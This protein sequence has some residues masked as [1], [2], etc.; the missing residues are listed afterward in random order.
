MLSGRGTNFFALHQ[1]IQ[2][3]NLHARIIG[4]LSN[5][6]DAPGI[7][8]AKQLGY[9][10]YVVPHKQY[11]SRRDHEKAIEA[12]ID[13]NQPDLIVL[14]G[15]MRMLTEAFVQKYPLK[16]VNIHPALLPS[17][18][19]IHAQKQAWAYGVKVTGC[20][21]HFVDTG[22]DT[23][24]IILQR[25]VPVYDHD[26]VETLEERI[27]KQEHQIYAEAIQMVLH[28]PWYQEGR[29]IIRGRKG[30]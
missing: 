25:V 23:G 8:K 14:A 13:E 9:T 17:F 22:M 2:E 3:G 30:S 29:R 5:V 16:I 18:P 12:I 20:T 11:A 6:P 7:E 15:Y 1:H 24:P 26:T 27:L 4:V 19:G 28:E 21:V 10:I